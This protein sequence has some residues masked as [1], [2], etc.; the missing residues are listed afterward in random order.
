MTDKIQRILVAIRDP[1]HIPA[2]QLRKSAAIAR[3]W[4]ASLELFHVV[5]K[6]ASIHSDDQGSLEQTALRKLQS[7]EHSPDFKGLKVQSRVTREYP[8]HE[9]I[10]QRALRSRADLVVTAPRPRTLGSR[11]ILRNTDWELIRHCPCQLLL[12]KSKGTYDKPEILTA[13]DPFHTHAKPVDLDARLLSVGESWARQL[14]GKQ[15]IFHAFLPLASAVPMP[16]GQPMAGWLAP[17]IEDLHAKQITR[18]FKDLA[19]GAAIDP[20]R[21]HLSVGDV[22]TEMERTV[23]RT[24]AR[25]VVMGA[26]ARGALKRFFIGNTAERLLD[27]VSSDILIVKPLATKAR[28]KS[29][30]NAPRLRAA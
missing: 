20:A 22:G 19:V 13:V 14:S 29:Q 12:I 11:L 27:S 28:S 6:A 24:N 8:A 25:I 17:E 9:V 26:I 2:A 15:H 5:E 30:K 18:A 7:I 16:S 1:W 3:A 10:L 21:R 4:D 23:K